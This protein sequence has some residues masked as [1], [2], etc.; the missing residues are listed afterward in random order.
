MRG[1]YD[2]LGLQPRALLGT[3][4]PSIQIYVI[5]YLSKQS[6]RWMSMSTGRPWQYVEYDELELVPMP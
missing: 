3:S 2:K 5:D 1:L 6:C 4:Q